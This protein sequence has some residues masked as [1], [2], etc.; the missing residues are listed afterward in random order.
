MVWGWGFLHPASCAMYRGSLFPGVNQSEH[1]IDHLPYR[2]LRL[3]TARAILLL[4]YLLWG[5]VLGS[6][7]P[8]CT[9]WL[10]LSVA[11]QM[12]IIRDHMENHKENCHA[13]MESVQMVNPSTSDSLTVHIMYQA[14]WA[15]RT[16]LKSVMYVQILTHARKWKGSICAAN[17]ML[18]SVWLPSSWNFTHRKRFEKKNIELW[19]EQRTFCIHSDTE[20]L[21]DLLWD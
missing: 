14:L 5:H 17:L 3:S 11:I 7:F 1:G 10:W 8:G 12:G 2:A 18:D 9:G 6:L 16:Q 4:P 15:E 21:Q 20:W 13:E 19:I